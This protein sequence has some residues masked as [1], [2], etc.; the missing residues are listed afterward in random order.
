MH[1][2]TRNL[3][4][5]SAPNCHRPEEMTVKHPIPEERVQLAANGRTYLARA[6]YMVEVGYCAH[7]GGLV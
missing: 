1:A 4:T 3:V 6:A 7:H 2:I 5:C